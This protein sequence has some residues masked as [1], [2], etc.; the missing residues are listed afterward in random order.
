MS[1][2]EICSV[3]IH[4]I[5]LHSSGSYEVATPGVGMVC[6]K[7]DL[8]AAGGVFSN[9]IGSR[10]RYLAGGWQPIQMG[11]VRIG[12]IA[13]MI[14]GYEHRDG[15]PIPFAALTASVPVGAIV[16]RFMLIPES[17]VAP[18]TLALAFSF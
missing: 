16:A 15:K 11:P 1:I 2:S 17:K 6:E 9:S 12:A 4:A 8:V 18:T 3:V 5:A 10:S 7:G 14:D 13:G